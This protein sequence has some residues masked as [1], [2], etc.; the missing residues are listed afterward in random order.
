MVNKESLQHLCCIQ[1]NFSSHNVSDVSKYCT[2]GNY[3]PISIRLA[4]LSSM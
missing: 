3:F 4:N 1:S 2:I